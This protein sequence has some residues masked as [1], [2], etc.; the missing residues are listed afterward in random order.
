MLLAKLLTSDPGDGVV[1]QQRIS[2]EGWI[3]TSGMWQG[4]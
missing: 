4:D 1:G 3:G 2:S